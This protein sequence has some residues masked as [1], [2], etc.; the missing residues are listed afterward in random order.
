MTAIFS[1]GVISRAAKM[2]ATAVVILLTPNLAPSFFACAAAPAVLNAGHLAAWEATGASFAQ[3]GADGVKIRGD[4]A[5]RLISPPYGISAGHA[6]V[7]RLKYFARGSG[8]VAAGFLMS[9]GRAFT[10]F[11]RLDEGGAVTDV[12]VYLRDYLKDGGAIERVMLQFPPG[13]EAWLQEA[14]FYEA[15][16]FALLSA[17]WS[18]LWEPEIIK[19]STINAIST[20]AFGPLNFHFIAYITLACSFVVVFIFLSVKNDF[21]AGQRLVLALAAGF[22]ISGLAY[23]ARLDYNWLMLWREDAKRLGGKT[24]NE[25][26]AA[27]YGVYGA[28]YSDFFAFIASAKASVPKGEKVKPLYR[29]ADENMLTI[30]K[31]FFLPVETSGSAKYTWVFAGGGEGL[32]FDPAS[33]T[34]KSGGN[35]IIAGVRPATAYKNKGMLLEPEGDG[36]R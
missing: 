21:R 22:F 4:G 8:F 32:S 10:R 19:A 1:Y 14:F 33:N 34:L 30:G 9:D 16:G 18:G 13:A 11:F 20:P 23:A 7:F 28:D 35:A 17:L 27:V 3:A 6:N 29:G 12:S 5:F 26:V 36:I 2:L 24:T 25:K 31:Y 15:S